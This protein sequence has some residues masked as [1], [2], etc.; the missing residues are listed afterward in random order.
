MVVRRIE[1]RSDRNQKGD[2]PEKVSFLDDVVQG[3]KSFGSS[4]WWVVGIIV[5]LIIYHCIGAYQEQV[6]F[7]QLEKEEAMNCMYQFKAQDCNP[8]NLTDKCT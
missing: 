5:A 4:L 3:K 2:K 8:L 6:S 1:L 7:Q